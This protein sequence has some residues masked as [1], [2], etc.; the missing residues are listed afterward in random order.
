MRKIQSVFKCV[1]C[2]KEFDRKDKLRKHMS[3]VHD[4]KKPFKCE[5][6]P[7]YFAQKAK[8]TVHIKLEHER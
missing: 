2:S 5:I 1:I 3:S 4:E 7:F 8:I 6:C